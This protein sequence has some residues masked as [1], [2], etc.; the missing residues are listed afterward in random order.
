MNA[1]KFCGDSTARI[2]RDGLCARCYRV[3]E[4]VRRQPEKTTP[5]DLE[6]FEDMCR[7]NE[8]YGLFVPRFRQQWH[9][10]RCGCTYDRDISYKKYCTNCA[11]VVRRDAAQ[12][13][14]VR[15]DKGSK[16]GQGHV[17]LYSTT[18]REW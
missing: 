7:F 12:H 15:S 8:R 11:T 1:C 10:A 5:E 6:W 9:C 18:K 17:A 3:I 13:R 14:R 16:R 2:N 4:R